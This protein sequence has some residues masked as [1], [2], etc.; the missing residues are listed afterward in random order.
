MTTGKINGEAIKRLTRTLSD[1]GES[2]RYVH[3]VAK[4][5]PIE[6]RE[7]YLRFAVTNLVK[8]MRFLGA[9]YT[10]LPVDP[11]TFIDSTLL[12]DWAEQLYPAVKAE[13]VDMCS[14]K[15]VETVL[16]GGIG[17]GK[18]TAALAVTAYGLYELSCMKSP[19]STYGLARSSE[20]MFI[21]QSL[22]ANLAKGVDFDRFKAMI[23][24]SVYFTTVFPRDK[25]REGEL[26]FPN[27][28]KIVPLSGDTKAAIGQNVI[29]GVIDEVNFME[30][31]ERSSKTVDG[32]KF[33]QAKEIYSSISRRRESRFMHKGRMPGMLCLVSSKR[34]PGEFTDVK[35]E[36]SKTNPK[37]K[38]YDKRTW[39]IKPES[40]SGDWFPL[41]KGSITEMPRILTD[42]DYAE[43]SRDRPDKIMMIPEEHRHQFENDIM[44]A[45]R[46]IAGVSTLALHPFM[47]N[48]KAVAAGFGN[49]KSILSRQQVDLVVTKTKYL[50]ENLQHPQEPRYVHIDLALTSDS[51][52]V[53]MGYVSGFKAVKRGDAVEMLPIIEYDFTLEVAPP[54]NG[55][56]LIEKVR[57]IL[58][59]LR[60]TYG[61]PIKFVS[62]DSFQSRDSIQILRS[63]G[64]LAGL[65]S[66][67]T[68]AAP[69]EMLKQAFYDSRI[70]AAEHPRLLTELLRLEQDEKTGKIDHPANF[71][72]DISDS[73]AGV[74]YGLTS[75]REIW[76]KHG[77][78]L[79]HAS[80][81]VRK[82][83]EGRPAGPKASTQEHPTEIGL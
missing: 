70:R 52:G 3:L 50:K 69:Y 83:M 18:T 25:S 31:T 12:L 23:D 56:I 41:F 80:D 67:D 79:S 38:V 35:I 74:A 53:S 26:R 77:I 13:V 65:L 15:Y 1:F 72:K 2:G 55:E 68:S 4:T 17:S 57:S 37:I 7:E 62:F 76:L 78:P 45:V 30:I 49:K 20:I 36:E 24:D 9:H 71:S 6:Q 32:G 34:F 43:M 73:M 21:F 10:E 82:A 81:V 60:D 44:D 16:T 46:D 29:G 48:S 11:L 51:C 22:N 61:I 39:E 42:D 5:R 27:N 19:Q 54:K 8:R 66:M 47:V 59:K 14:G 75:R 33:D 64:F 28:I 63:K 40:V 58:Y